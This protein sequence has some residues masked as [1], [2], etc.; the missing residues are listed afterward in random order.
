[1]QADEHGNPILATF[2]GMLT[3]CVVTT[4][5]TGK[6]K[7]KEMAFMGFT[8]VGGNL[9]CVCFSDAWAV[10]MASGGLPQKGKVYMVMACGG[11]TPTS[12]I[13]CGIQ[14]LSNQGVSVN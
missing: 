3:R 13:I 1:M 11:R 9:E 7:G 6:S 8:G 10:I 2:L 14:R 4:V 5:K 12:P